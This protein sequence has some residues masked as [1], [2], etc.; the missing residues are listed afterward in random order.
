MKSYN[1]NNFLYFSMCIKSRKLLLCRCVF[2]QVIILILNEFFQVFFLCC[3]EHLHIFFQREKSYFSKL[4]EKKKPVIMSL[5]PPPSPRPNSISPPPTSLQKSKMVVGTL[6]TRDDLYRKKQIIPIYS[7]IPTNKKEVKDHVDDANKTLLK[8]SSSFFTRA[9]RLRLIELAQ[10]WSD[11]SGL[12]IRIH[13]GWVQAISPQRIFL[14]PQS[15]Y[16][17]LFV[18]NKQE[19]TENNNSNNKNNNAMQK[20]QKV[21]KFPPSLIGAELMRWRN[22]SSSMETIPMLTSPNLSS[23]VVGELCP[24]ESIVGTSRLHHQTAICV[25][26]V[27][28]ISSFSSSIMSPVSH[29]KSAHHEVGD[30]IDSNLNNNNRSKKVLVVMTFVE[31]LMPVR[32]LKHD[33]INNNNN[34]MQTTTSHEKKT[35]HRRRISA[36]KQFV[37]L[38]VGNGKVEENGRAWLRPELFVPGLVRAAANLPNAWR[39][40]ENPYPEATKTINSKIVQQEEIMRKM[41]QTRPTPPLPHVSPQQQQTVVVVVEEEADYYTSTGEQGE[42]EEIPPTPQNASTILAFSGRISPQIFSMEFS[43]PVCSLANTPRCS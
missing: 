5:L 38:P 21:R 34:T 32:M 25:K 7:S 27:P 31:C 14:L 42:D 26:A 37:F 35:S 4:R 3:P 19:E 36:Q 2:F 16:G 10:F 11:T 8:I 6:L 15:C 40:V 43:P 29:K 12:W 39:V 1:K 9:N 23:A 22:A 41:N 13:S 28:A 24:G 33:H 18:P 30:E 20:P 17:A